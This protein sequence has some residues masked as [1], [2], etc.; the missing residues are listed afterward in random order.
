MKRNNKIILT[1]GH[2]GT[3][4][5]SVV[6]EIQKQKLSWQIYWIGPKNAIEGKKTL[7]LEFKYFSKFNIKFYS[8]IF[9]K[10]QRKFSIWTI[11]SVFKIP[12]GF[13]QALYF[14]IKIKPFV[15][16]S[17]GGFASFPVV[18][19]SKLFKI[20]VLIH[21]QTTVAGR[22]N[23]LSAKFAEKILLSRELSEPYFPK[24]KCLVVGNPILSQYFK[25]TKNLQESDR[26][27]IFIVGGSR[28]SQQINKIIKIAL[29]KLLDKYK[30]IHTTGELDYKEFKK[31]KDNLSDNKSRYYSLFSSIDPYE[32]LTIYNQVD[33]VISRAGA[34]TVSELIA[35]GKPS[36]FIPIPWAYLN[37]QTKNAEY[38][39][40]YIPTVILNQSS[41]STEKLFDGIEYL[42][43]SSTQA[44]KNN[45]LDKEASKKIVSL[46]SKYFK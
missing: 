11:L 23:M 38:A 22:A 2:A 34:N 10:L 46:L 31:I 32:M 17:F 44:R 37:E 12:V 45:Y 24:N 28:G 33:L 3:A 6:E 41:L 43:N 42:V 19:M 4:A 18:V 27:T 40:K 39:S 20:P 7:S 15:V 16:L 5:L 21:E 26:K 25:E 9:G 1:G 36:I 30:I 13:V 35:L 8:I 14:L 29:E